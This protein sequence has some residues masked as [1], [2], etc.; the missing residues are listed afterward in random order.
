MFTVV[1]QARNRIWV[2]ALT[3]HLG[4]QYF[5]DDAMF[6]AHLLFLAALLTNCLYPPILLRMRS[7]KRQREWAAKVDVVLDSCYILCNYTYAGRR[8]E[9]AD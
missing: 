3:S 8:L 5:G 1:L 6:G 9:P 7:V 4:C 2:F